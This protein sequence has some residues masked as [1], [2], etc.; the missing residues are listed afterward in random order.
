MSFEHVFD[1]LEISTHPFAVCELRGKCDMDIGQEANVSLHY[2]LTGEGELTIQ[3]GPAIQVSPGSLVLVPALQSH[4]LHSYGIANESFLKCDSPELKLPH[5]LKTDHTGDGQ[6]TALCSHLQVGLRGV[7]DVINLIRVPIV[8]RVGSNDSLHSTLH[9]LLKELGNPTLGSRAMI[10]TLLTQ[11]VIEMLRK[12]LVH[13]DGGLR[14]MAALR[15]STMWKA[16]F[17]MLDEPGAPHTVESLAHS[18]GMSRS[19]FA[20]RFTDAYGSGPI[21]LLRDLRMRRAAAL[22][23]SS[24]LPVKRIAQLVGFNSRTAFSR[25]FEQ[26]SGQSPTD[27]R[28]DVEKD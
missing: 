17:T 11:C 19:A 23:R 4:A 16:L 3:G 1:Q 12:R 24:N 10:R 15:D 8:E 27:Y 28:R 21:E 26:R 20:E 2:I 25:V 6:V 14:W 22:L 7:V 13:D 18:V 5:M 9:Q